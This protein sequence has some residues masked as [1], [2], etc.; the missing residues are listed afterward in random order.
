M[1]HTLSEVNRETCPVP[2]C[3]ICVADTSIEREL[4][5]MLKIKKNKFHFN[6]TKFF[7]F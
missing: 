6:I 3:E 2:N 1:N 4:A 7:I 5:G